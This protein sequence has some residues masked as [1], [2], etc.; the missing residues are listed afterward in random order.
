MLPLDAVHPRMAQALNN[1]VLEAPHPEPNSGRG[2]GYLGGFALATTLLMGVALVHSPL[3]HARLIGMTLVFLL[4]V[5]FPVLR[6]ARRSRQTAQPSQKLRYSSEPI[7]LTRA[8]QIYGDTLFLLASQPDIG[9]KAL[10]ELLSN[11][12]ALLE[13]SYRLEAQQ[14]Q[15]GAALAQNTAPSLGAGHGAGEENTRALQQLQ[16][17]LAAQQEVVVQELTSVHFRLVQGPPISK[18]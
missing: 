1:Q 2:L 15:V 10:R 12:N 11:L 16:E 6:I 3:L 4:C 18:Q 5:A 14:K 17:R 7:T 9:E 8:E 13:C